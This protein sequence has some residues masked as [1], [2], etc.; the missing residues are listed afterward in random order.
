MPDEHE[1]AL[2]LRRMRAKVATNTIAE[3]LFGRKTLEF[4]SAAGGV[5]SLR[6]RVECDDGIQLARG[7]SGHNFR[8]VIWSRICLRRVAA[9]THVFRVHSHFRAFHFHS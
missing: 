1:A 9:R 3:V 6:A 4:N 8:R 5:S 2:L 7:N